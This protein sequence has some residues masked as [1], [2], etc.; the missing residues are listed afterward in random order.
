MLLDFGL[1]PEEQLLSVNLPLLLEQGCGQF[2]LLVYV[3]MLFHQH[4]SFGQQAASIRYLGF[5]PQ[6]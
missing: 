6:Y 1:G 4:V 3:S 2:D 5:D